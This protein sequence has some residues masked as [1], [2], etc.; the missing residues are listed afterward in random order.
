MR[1]VLRGPPRET[2]LV[3]LSRGSDAF[4]FL[5]CHLCKRTSGSADRSDLR[6]Y[7]GLVMRE[8]STLVIV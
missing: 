5:G 3:D 8:S 7:A 6:G 4:D 1:S 2:R